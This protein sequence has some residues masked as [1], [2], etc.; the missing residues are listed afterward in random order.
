MPNFNIYYNQEKHLIGISILLDSFLSKINLKFKI[1]K[2][3]AGCGVYICSLEGGILDL[4]G[5]SESGESFNLLH[6]LMS[7]LI[8]ILLSLFFE[9]ILDVDVLDFS[10]EQLYLQ[11][12]ALN[13]HLQR[14]KLL[15][16]L[17]DFILNTIKLGDE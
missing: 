11:F 3:V 5:T 10:F 1:N 14:S 6:H 12:L 9:L 7:L 4:E 15:I 17:L 8:H 2:F 16:V 13:I